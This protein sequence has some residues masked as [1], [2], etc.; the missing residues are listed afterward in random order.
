MR[1]VNTIESRRTFSFTFTR[2]NRKRPFWETRL[3]HKNQTLCFWPL[4][5]PTSNRLGLLQWDST[6]TTDNEHSHR[7]H[8]Q[9]HTHVHA[10][11]HKLRICFITYISLFTQTC[12]TLKTMTHKYSKNTCKKNKKDSDCKWEQML[13]F[14][15]FFPTRKQR[16]RLARE[17]H[18]VTEG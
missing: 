15:T 8:I 6:S 2:S 9:I 18:E 13:Q 4:I 11:T 12:P 16:G 5:N 10:N 7:A 17:P 14:L 3:S 1:H